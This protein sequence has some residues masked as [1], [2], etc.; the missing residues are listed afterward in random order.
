MVEVARTNSGFAEGGKAAFMVTRSRD[1]GAIPY[2]CPWTRP[3][4]S[5]PAPW[6]SIRPR[7]RTIPTNR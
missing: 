6:R 1:N 2:P 7:T 3:G 5:C 4:I